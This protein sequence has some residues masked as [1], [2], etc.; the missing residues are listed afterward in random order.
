MSSL[1]TPNTTQETPTWL[2][3]IEAIIHK[4]FL[5]ANTCLPGEVQS[6]DAATGTCS[7]QPAIKRKYVKDDEVVDLPIINNVPI[8]YPRAGTNGSYVS[9]E[10]GRHGITR[11]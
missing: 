8:A 5:Q 1:G 6:F 3:A 4:H 10:K 9:F 11:I 2:G 7:V